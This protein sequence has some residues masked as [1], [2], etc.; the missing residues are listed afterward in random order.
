MGD[1]PGGGKRNR[2]R[3][4]KVPAWMWISQSGGPAVSGDVCGVVRVRK[5][6]DILRANSLSEA[7]LA[8]LHPLDLLSSRGY[9]P[10]LQLKGHPVRDPAFILD[11]F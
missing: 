8:R 6:V 5:Q 11:T 3:G 2:V 7:H 10:R 9:F 4:A 1:G